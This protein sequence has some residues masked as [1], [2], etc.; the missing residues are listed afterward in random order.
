MQLHHH[1]STAAHW[2]MKSAQTDAMMLHIHVK[3][4]SSIILSTITGSFMQPLVNCRPWIVHPP[5]CVCIFKSLH[6]VCSALQ[7]LLWDAAPQHAAP[8]NTTQHD[9]AEVLVRV[10]RHLHHGSLENGK[11]GEALQRASVWT[12]VAL[13]DCW[14]TTYTAAAHMQQ[15]YSESPCSSRHQLATA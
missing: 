5:K 1:L 10:H 2:A 12:E 6:H 13:L 15:W 9:R 7:Q 14:D 3:T 4:S 11:D 8:A